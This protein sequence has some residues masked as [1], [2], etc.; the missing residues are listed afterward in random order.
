MFYT[1]WGPRCGGC[2]HAH[3][4]TDSAERCVKQYAQDSGEKPD[5]GVREI[6]IPHEA[7][8]YPP[9]RGPG[10]IVAT[11]MDIWAHKDGTGHSANGPVT[12]M[13]CAPLR[14]KIQPVR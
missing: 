6:R 9:K 8:E 12:C 5:R 1:T 3:I 4:T 2:G 10:R 11:A 14:K 7:V 13:V